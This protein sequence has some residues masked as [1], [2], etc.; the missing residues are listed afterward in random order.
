MKYKFYQ[1]ALDDKKQTLYH[2]GSDGVEVEIDITKINYQVLLYFVQH[3]EEVVTKDQIIEAVWQG[4]MV[5]DNSI[6]QSISK[7]RKSLAAYD[8]RVVIKTAYG[9]GLELAPEVTQEDEDSTTTVSPN[10]QPMKWLVWPVVAVL[11]LLAVVRFAPQLINQPK[12]GMQPT[13]MWLSEA[14]DE[15]WQNQSGQQLLHQVFAQTGVNYQ[16]DS[17]AKPKQLSNQEYIDNYWR[18][19]PELEV[20]KTDLQQV[21]DQYTLNIEVATQATVK[22]GSFSGSNLLKIL[23]DANRWLIANSHLIEPQTDSQS[24]LPQDPHVL[25]LHLRSLHAFAAGQLDQALNYVQLAV[26]Q[27]PTF[28][29]GWLQLAQVQYA[30]GESEQSLAT[31]DKLKSAPL[32]LQF[33]I[34]EQALRGD[35]LDTAGEQQQAIEIFQQLLNKYPDEAQGKLLPVKLNLSYSLAATQRYTEA[36]EVL[37]E[38]VLALGDQFDLD[39]LAHAWHKKGSVLLQI[40]QTTAAKEAANLAYQHF[41]DLSDMM[42]AA[43]VSI[44]LARIANHESDYQQAADYLQQ[45]I[46]IYRHAEYPLGVGATLNELIYTLMVDGRFTQAWSH[47]LEMRQIALDIDYFAMLMAAKQFEVEIARAREQWA[48]AEAALEDYVRLATDNSFTRGLFKKQ[49][50][51]LDL[52]LDQAQAERAQTIIHSI[53][54]H[55]DS[56]GEERLQPRINTQQARVYFI[57]GNAQQAI[58]LLNQT[59][60]MALLTEDM[61][62]IHAI[63]NE[64]LQYHVDHQQYTAAQSI[65]ETVD[66]SNTP[67]V[68]YPYLLLK[69]KILSGLGDHAEAIKWAEQCKNRANE[70]WRPADELYLKS[71]KAN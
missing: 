46:G 16:L 4:K 43:K 11:V 37:N 55:I 9:K 7:I 49:L 13:V 3:H 24:L 47:M 59:K 10:K 30:Q 38:V 60:A 66:Q 52:A 57:Q 33:E 31:L 64:L 56:S 20:I 67:P 14:A 28:A 27:E 8:D 1:F 51:E 36:L 41:N 19:N 68:A 18:I 70:F 23:T 48:I 62:S 63:N 25:E 39:L 45:S 17:E 58:E 15:D 34:A 21:D 26:R 22:N 40:G 65:I 53:Q 29:L 5:T 50:F 54:Q 35:I 6:D 12:A 69:S 32:Y 71:L 61:E 44:L 2:T 42:G